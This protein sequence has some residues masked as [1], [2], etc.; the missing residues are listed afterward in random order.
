MI[1]KILAVGLA[2]TVALAT[3][4]CSK[5]A[6]SGG[7]QHPSG[8]ETLGQVPGT[9][10]PAATVP[11]G[12]TP[13]VAATGA[14]PTAAAL[15]DGRHPG[16]IRSMTSDN[17]SMKFD[18][19]EWLTGDAAKK[20]YLADNPGQTDGPPNDYYIVNKNP[21][22]RTLSISASVVV[23]IYPLGPGDPQQTVITGLSTAFNGRL[24]ASMVWLTVD[25]GIVTKIEQQWV[26]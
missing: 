4:A 10:A 7:A 3:A 19:V 12:A 18:L 20:A 23:I 25:H 8:A 15:P 22:L 6:P 14:E 5:D 13:S 1:I 9:T 17:R 2:G 24:D 11:A 26:P 21:M 16:Y